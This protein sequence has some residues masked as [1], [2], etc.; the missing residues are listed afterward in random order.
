MN[1]AAVSPIRFL[2]HGF[3]DLL[4]PPLCGL[5]GEKITAPAAKQKVVCAACA[6]QLKTIRLP[7]CAGCGRSLEGLVETVTLC[8]ECRGRTLYYEQ[9]RSCFLYE[10][11]VKEAIHRLKYSGRISFLDFFRDRFI[12]YLRENPALTDDIE[13]IIAVPLHHVRF[14]E[15][16]FN[17][18]AILA[19]AA[20][21]EFRTADLSACLQ[22]IINTNP[23]SGL[24]KGSRFENVRGAF[25]VRDPDA[26]ALKKIL[27]ID[28]VFTT[29]STLNEC[30]RVLK[31][32]GARS[33][34]CCTFARGI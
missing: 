5:C 21:Q 15:R 18:A 16:G 27:L 29:G 20:A 24:D 23:Q 14:R 22:R 9:S 26:V 2:I 31:G 33:V 19:K 1:A 3:F 32:A 25:E 7:C 11:T 8:P 4:Y 28:D 10:G 17:Q 6:A 34:R 30:S 12:G 13:G